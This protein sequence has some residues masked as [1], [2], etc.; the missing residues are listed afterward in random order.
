MHL[1]PAKSH[2]SGKMSLNALKQHKH[3]HQTLKKHISH[4]INN[5]DLLQAKSIFESKVFRKNFSL[6]SQ[7]LG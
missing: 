6:F 5:V 2:D 3:V 4:K 7:L 1:L